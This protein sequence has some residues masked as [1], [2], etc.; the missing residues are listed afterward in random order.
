MAAGRLVGTTTSLQGSITNNSIVRFDQATAGTFLG[1][2]SG[3]GAVEK[4]GAGTVVLAAANSHAGGTTVNAG[5]LA[6]TANGGLGTPGATTGVIFGTGAGADPATGTAR[7]ANWTMVAVPSTW[8]PPEAVPYPAYVVQTVANTYVGGNNGSNVQNGYTANGTTSY[9]I[10]PQSTI[11]ALVGGNYNWIVAQ[12]F[13]VVRDGAYDFSFG[14]AGDDQISFF[15]DGTVNTSNSVLP[16]ITGG[17]QI[18]STWASFNTIGTLTGTANLLAGTHTAYMV[19]NDFGGGTGAIITPGSFTPPDGTIVKAGNTLDLQN[20]AYT[21]ADLI[22][23]EA[24]TLAASTGT[25]SWAGG[26]VTTGGSTVAVDGAALSI[27]GVVSGT[28]SLT[29]SGSG[30]LILSAANTYGGATSVAGGRLSV[31]GSLASSAVTVSGGTLGGSGNIAG[32]VAVQNGGTLAPGNSIESLASGA[33]TF[34]SGST[35]AYEVDSSDLGALGTAADLLVVSGDL[36]ITSGTL[37]TFADV[38]NTPQPF[39]QDTTIFALINYTGTWNNGLFT[40]GTNELADG[41][42]FAVGSQIW[43]IDYNYAYVPG[44]TIQPL[45]FTAS[46]NTGGSYVTVTSVPEPGT[47]MLA[48]LA[49]AILAFAAR[50]RRA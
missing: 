4:N 17:T 15:I 46:Q 38:N 49:A 6:V 19:L 22:T 20:V 18:G 44:T 47:L 45:N 24:A 16:V 11:N 36:T 21:T 28:G 13:N 29:K 5:T 8:T 1:T 3:S 31:N 26:V 34:D 40:Y 7:D 50:R 30:N 35:F 33:A 2:I 23:L 48:G 27:A 42:R 25:S 41:E 10:A 32:T 43:E 39:V 37:L 14:G 12:E 9:W